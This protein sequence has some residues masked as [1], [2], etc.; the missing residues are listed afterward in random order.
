[1]RLITFI[2]YA[3]VVIGV[4][5]MIAGQFFALPRGFHFGVFMTGAGIALGGLEGIVT[6]RMCFR[7]SEDAYEAYAGAPAVIVGT[8][9][10]LVGAGVIAA[11]YLLEEG[12]WHTTVNYLTRRPA[13]VLV[14]AGVLLIGIGVVMTLNPQGRIGFAWTLLVFLPR[15]L[16]GFLLVVAGLAGI[17]LG[18]WEWLE[19]AAFDGFVRKLQQRLDQLL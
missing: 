7:P 9:V 3:A 18:A 19:P 12:L 16:L 17:G 15:A 13:P 2:E 8:M 14:A 10:L 4:I 6:R 5:G 1:V 11:A